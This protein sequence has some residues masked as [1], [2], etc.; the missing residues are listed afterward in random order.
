LLLRQTGDYKEDEEMSKTDVYKT[1][2]PGTHLGTFERQREQKHGY[3]GETPDYNSGMSPMTRWL[4]KAFSYAD[5]ESQPDTGYVMCK[6]PIHPNTIILRAMVRVDTAFE[7]TGTDSVDIG[8][9]GTA[10]AAPG[11]G[12]G[13]NLN[14]QS[15]GLKFDPDADYNPAGSSGPQL[16]TDGDTVDMLVSSYIVPTAGYGIL[17]LEVITYNEALNAEW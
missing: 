2:K 14:L 4:A 1:D 10:D 8:T 16:Y 9:G 5:F 12:W 11:D 3:T 13:E 15:T 7:G 17:F 6:F